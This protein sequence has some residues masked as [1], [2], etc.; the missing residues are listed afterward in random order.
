MTRY[1]RSAVFSGMALF[2]V[3]CGDG[4]PMAGVPSAGTGSG[5]TSG[6][7]STGGS[8][9]GGTVTPYD[10]AFPPPPPQ[11]LRATG[12]VLASPRVIPVFFTGDSLQTQ[13]NSFITNYVTRSS[14]WNVLQEYGV[15]RGTV[16]SAVV[17]SGA[18]A[19]QMD[20][21]AVKTLVLGRIQDGSLPKPDANTLYTVYFPS[22][23][24]LLSD[25][26]T[27]CV[28]FAGYHTFVK[29]TDGTRAALAVLPRCR[30]TTLALLT[31]ATSHELAEAA[32]D[33]YLG[34]WN[35]LIDPYALW[36]IP[37]HG[38]EL[39][40]L[41]ENLS[42][43][44]YSESGIGVVTRLFSNAAMAAYK[45][46]CLPAPSGASFFS[47]A[48]PTELR[49]VSIGN[50][51]HQIETVAVPI[52]Q[53]RS[54]EVRSISDI[55]PGPSWTVVASEAPLGGTKALSFAW[56]EAPGQ[57]RATTRD[58]GTLHL[59]VTASSTAS[60]GFTT[61]LLTATGTTSTGGQTQTMWVE[62]VALTR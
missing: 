7:S 21:A 18:L 1:L 22:S 60:T 57:T 51:L 12:E 50:D 62:T 26:G 13:L 43:A 16:G 31:Y 41:C 34:A 14:S 10:P 40:D 6:S 11:V 27:S 55:K 25:G 2:L 4:S 42:D 9:T 32:T 58:G 53:T 8:T 48:R 23:V 37:L 24:T 54:I 61:I 15:G 39:G 29:Q 56:Q 36:A 52:G 17:L 33:P 30:Q 44:A 46:P 45:N 47:I 5:T 35:T 49:D 59:Q 19:S 28:D 20:E 3:A 38:A